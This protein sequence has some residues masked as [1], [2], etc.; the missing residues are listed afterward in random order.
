[1][2][3]SC[4]IFL[5]VGQAIFQSSLAHG[6]LG[7]VSQKEAD[8]IIAAGAADVHRT[9]QPVDHDAVTSVYNTAVTNVFVST[10]S[11]QQP[12]YRI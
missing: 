2:T 6:L 12:V 8:T 11:F 4:S 3:A 10:S 9:T 5:A 1:M 7:V